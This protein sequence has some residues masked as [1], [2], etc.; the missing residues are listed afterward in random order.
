MELVHPAESFTPDLAFLSRYPYETQSEIRSL[1]AA[2]HLM[3]TQGWRTAWMNIAAF[4]IE[5]K[6]A[7]ERHDVP[8]LFEQ[9]LRQVGPGMGELREMMLAL[10]YYKD[11][12]YR[13]LIGSK[14]SP[15]QICAVV[16]QYQAE[17][18]EAD[19]ESVTTYDVYTEVEDLSFESLGGDDVLPVTPTIAGQT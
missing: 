4:C 12:K 15:A 6:N 17:Q 7:S 5:L 9:C 14:V 13:S 8:E 11:D 19:I 18:L 2:K 10:E 3:V 16:R 1:F